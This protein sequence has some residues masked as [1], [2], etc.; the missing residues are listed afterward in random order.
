MFG[1]NKNMIREWSFVAD[2]NN[3]GVFDC[4]K[5]RVLEGDDGPDLVVIEG[6]GDD[7]DGDYDYAPAAWSNLLVR[8]RRNLNHGV[9]L[10]LKNVLIS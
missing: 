9:I 8:G 2:G 10:E 3:D 5:W 4:F 7:D 6:D 1:V